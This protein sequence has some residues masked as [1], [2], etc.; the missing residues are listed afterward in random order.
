MN[1]ISQ[2]R[3]FT[4]IELLIV[5]AISA[6][7][8]ALLLPAVQQA[9][10]AA[11]RSTCKNNMKQLGLALHNYHDTHRV[12]P[13]GFV[14]IKNS[15]QIG[16]QTFISP[17]I[18]Q[19]P[20]YNDLQ[21]ATDGWNTDWNANLK[22][23]KLAKTVITAYQ[24]PTDPGSGKK[25]GGKGT[26]LNTRWVV[27]AGKDLKDTHVATSNYLANKKVFFKNSKVRMRDFTDGTSNT[28]MAGERGTKVGYGGI[29]IGAHRWGK[30]EGAYSSSSIL[31]DML[32]KDKNVPFTINSKASLAH[33][34]N[35]FSSS[36]VGGA[37]FNI[38]DGRVR[39]LSENINT[40]IYHH[41]ATYAGGEAIGEY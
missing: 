28:V 39:F 25:N 5:S 2:K 7:L 3:G 33:R 26:G 8:A 30:E 24:C 37:H 31:G 36:H 6:V 35:T 17:F 29:W 1:N 15:N 13:P 9:R 27:K 16:W 4:V 22:A 14:S 19:A 18:D 12:F 32:G 10:E 11:R 20:L 38:G 41:L 21:S 34:M 23:V 40:K